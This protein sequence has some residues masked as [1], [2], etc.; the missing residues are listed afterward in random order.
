MKTARRSMLLMLSV[1]GL[2]VIYIFQKFDYLNSITGN[3][4][5][6]HPDFVF[7]FNRLS[8][9]LINDLLAILL[10]YS[11]FWNKRYV[12]LGLLITLFELLIILPVYF[13]FKLSLEGNSEI[14]SPLLSFLHRITIHPI[15]ILLL[16]PGIY[17]QSRHG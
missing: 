15:L 6:F 5:S 8:R 7:V 16:I 1:F 12:Y 17:L 3:S 14:S 4:S 13:Y 2:I 10:I 9:F 11:V